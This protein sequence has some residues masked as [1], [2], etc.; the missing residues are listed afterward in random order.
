MQRPH[1]PGTENSW[2]GE[3]G[4]CGRCSQR[5]LEPT[6][7]HRLWQGGGAL[8]REGCALGCVLCDGVR[9]EGLGVKAG[10]CTEEEDRGGSQNHPG[11]CRWWRGPRWCIGQWVS[12]YSTSMLGSWGHKRPVLP[13]EECQQHPFLLPTWQRTERL[14]VLPNRSSRTETGQLSLGTG[15]CRLSHYFL[16]TI[17]LENEP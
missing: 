12:A 16:Q 7:A 2:V 1:A 6:G 5:P 10:V 15:L 13:A 17:C 8:G 14:L 4:E 11:T 3:A 9:G